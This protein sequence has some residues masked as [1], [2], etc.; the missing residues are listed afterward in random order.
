M[1]LSSVKEVYFNSVHIFSFTT[2]VLQVL[3]YYKKLHTSISFL[4]F[5]PLIFPHYDTQK[6]SIV[7]ADFTKTF[8][9]TLEC[10]ILITL[11]KTRPLKFFKSKQDGLTKE[12]NPANETLKIGRSRKKLWLRFK[13]C[14]LMAETHDMRFFWS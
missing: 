6:S 5:A 4:L 8:K 9:A 1:P 10:A 13:W 2:A 11:V 14:F 7:A 3:L 12:K